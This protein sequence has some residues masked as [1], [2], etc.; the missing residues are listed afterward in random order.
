AGD[1]AQ[2][3]AANAGRSMASNKHSAA[4]ER[5]ANRVRRRRGVIPTERGGTHHSSATTATANSS[6]NQTEPKIGSL[7]REYAAADEVSKAIQGMGKGKMRGSQ[8]TVVSML[9]GW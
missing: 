3:P 6:T 8:R 4:T 2:G 1:G 9:S 5:K 7:E